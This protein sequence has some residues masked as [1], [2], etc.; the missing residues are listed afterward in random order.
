MASDPP[1]LAA[2]PSP[3]SVTLLL[4]NS[5]STTLLSVQPTSTFDD[6]KVLLLAALKSR[7]VP[8]IP[9]SPAA[10]ELGV[11]ADRRDTSKGWVT[12]HQR[13]Q[14]LATGKHAK[15][16]ASGKKSALNDSVEG[17][18][19]VDGS[20][21]AWRVRSRVGKDENV[22]TDEDG[23]EM[24]IDIDAEEDPGWDVVIPSYEDEEEDA[25]AA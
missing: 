19:L 9:E 2:L 1:N 3:I 24:S 25:A 8:D 4:K 15:K 10:L 17:A 12:L 23:D 14:E 21:V 11:L 18:G 7:N 20:W 6:I 16:A 13:V 5:K 22:P